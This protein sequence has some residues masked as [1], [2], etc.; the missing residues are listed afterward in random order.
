MRAVE[1]KKRLSGD[2]MTPAI[3]IAVL[4]PYMD[5]ILIE[6]VLSLSEVQESHLDMRMRF[7]PEIHLVTLRL[8]PNTTRDQVLDA[9]SELTDD[10]RQKLYNLQ[11]HPMLKHSAK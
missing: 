7:N 3:W 8:P 10:E 1:G 9:F 11:Q 2:G 6:G 5:G 4:R